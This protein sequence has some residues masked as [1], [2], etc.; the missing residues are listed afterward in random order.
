M[1]KKVRAYCD[2]RFKPVTIASVLTVILSIPCIKYMPL[3]FGWENGPLENLQMLVLFAGMI[4]AFR[5][6]ENKKFFNFAALV[7]IILA[8]REVNCGRTIFFPIPGEINEYYTWKQLKY[9]WLAHPLYG[10][11]MTYVGLYFIIKKAYLELYTLIKNV[12]FPV[13]DILFMFLGIGCGMYAEKALN[14]CV[15]EECAELL[16]YVALISIIWTYT[17]VRAGNNN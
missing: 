15:V 14:N 11:Y 1:L 3:Q 4:I 8:L 10:L 16:F 17:R 7:L 2:F 5:A 12:K 6:K 13:W 9:G